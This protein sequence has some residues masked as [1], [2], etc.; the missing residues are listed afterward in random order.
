MARDR[1]RYDKRGKCVG[2]TSDQSPA[3]R[4]CG[5]ILGAIFFLGFLFLMCGGCR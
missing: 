5:Q 2:H 3:E 4:G 1:Y